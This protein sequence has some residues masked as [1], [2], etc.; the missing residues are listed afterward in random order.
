MCSILPYTRTEIYPWAGQTLTVTETPSESSLA[1][2]PVGKELLGAASPATSFCY[3]TL[4]FTFCNTGF[5]N[6]SGFAG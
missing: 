4:W 5:K 2:W 1:Q 3:L 6:P